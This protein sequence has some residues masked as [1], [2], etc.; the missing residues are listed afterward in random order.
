[1]AFMGEKIFEDYFAEFQS[2]MVSICLEYC[3]KKADVI[4]ILGSYEADMLSCHW[5]YDFDGNIVRK[6]KINT[7]SPELEVTV[8]RQKQCMAILVQNM[9]KII[10]LCKEYERPMPTEIRLIYDANTHKIDAKYSYEPMWSNHSTKL[11][12]DILDEWIQELSNIKK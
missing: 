7:I 10:E 6:H 9:K 5:F 8:Q 11:S 3:N 2:N 4:Y 12:N 1:M